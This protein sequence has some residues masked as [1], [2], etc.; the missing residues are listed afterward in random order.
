MLRRI[1]TIKNVGRFKNS[2]SVPNP[3]LKRCT[4]LFGSNGYGKTTLCAIL[5]SLQSGDGSHVGGRRSIGAQH[6]P[7]IDLL[8]STG[9]RTFRNGQWNATE[10]AL[11]IFDG[12]FVAQNVHSGDVVDINHRR[13]LY[14]IIVGREGV[15]LAEQEMVLADE[16]RRTQADLTAAE[17][18]LDAVVP[19]AVRPRNV[20]RDEFI[21]LPAEI[22]LD[23]KLRKQSR[24]LES[25]RQA[26]ALRARPQL[27]LLPVPDV[28]HNIAELLASTTE[29]VDAA[30]ETRL[31]E[32]LARHDMQENG[33]RWIADALPHIN[34]DECPFCGR[35]GLEALPLIRSY[36][37]VFA[38]EYRRILDDVTTG[39]ESVTNLLGER[40]GARLQTL[41]A[42]N[43]AAAEF[44]IQHCDINRGALQ[45]EE[46]AIN[47]LESGHVVL[48]SLLERKA[49]APLTPFA[50]QA[51]INE[52]ARAIGAARADIERYNAAVTVANV[53]IQGKKEAAAAVNLAA[54]EALLTRLRTTQRRYEQPVVD[55]VADY[56]RL[57][58]AKEDIERRKANVRARLEAHAGRVVQPYEARINYFL[59]R[60]N[61]GFKV[62]RTGHAYPGGA[63]ASTYQILINN[64][65]VELGDERTPPGQPSFKNTLS[66]GDRT[67]LALAFFLASLERE[68]DLADRVVV[69]DDPFSSHDAFRRRQTVFEILKIA[70]QCRQV[71][72]LSHDSHFLKLLWDKV[73]APDRTAIQISSYG[74][75]GSK[76]GQFDLEEACRGRANAELDDLLAFRATRRGD[77]REVIKKLRVVLE[78]YFRM[79]YAGSFGPADNCGEIL[80][81]IR[82]GG[83]QHPAHACYEHLERINDYTSDYHHGE[84]A[85]GPEPPLD[86]DEL[87]GFV[88][89]TL[90]LVNALN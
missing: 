11:S 50:D 37:V 77:P 42:Q 62:T 21:A 47:Q 22:E 3:E 4:L 67:T 70:E 33:E 82:E 9:N 24:H 87:A 58:N 90:R 34:H 8:F 64:I 55:A 68:A 12:A 79:A 38:A 36:R 40:S 59:E 75:A 2:T 83:E 6:S 74:G 7:E 31:R 20:R 29:N 17:R 41:A 60:F 72:V 25:L 14:R 86:S 78:T 43:D 10:A 71:I 76:I 66:A 63:A 49:R 53:Q 57:K 65:G 13:S 39:I 45:L 88:N 15:A 1:I 5:R 46:Q 84:D 32:H 26:A 23:E 44:W 85:R 73:A 16:S 48:H 35:D 80:R 19:Q 51:R 61:A 52:A 28:P 54:E 18:A 69:F 89:D 56:I 30:A 27:A 81:K